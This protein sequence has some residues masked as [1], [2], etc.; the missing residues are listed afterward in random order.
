MVSTLAG[1]WLRTT[2]GLGRVALAWLIAGVGAAGPAL[3]HDG[4]GRGGSMLSLGD[5]VVFG[6]ITSD[7]PAY[8][9][10]DNFLGYPEIAGDSLR[11]DSVNAACPGETSAGFLS[12]T[13]PDYKCQ[14]FRTHFPLHES[15]GGTQLD[16][17]LA[18]LGAN[19][20]KTR[21]VTLSIGANDVFLLQAEC[22]G[23]A[24]CI[25]AGLPT[26]LAQLYA[27]VNTILSNLK[28]T[29]FK[30]VLMVVNYYS[31]DYSDPAQ[32]GLTLALNHALANAAAA[33]GAVVAD[34]FGAFQKVAAAAGGKTCLAGLLNGDPQNQQACDVH[35]SLS[36]QRLL[37]KAV[38]AAY[39][40][41]KR[42]DD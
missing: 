19:K 20:R 12:L 27:N 10:P 32:T 29:G 8:V 13:G 1:V 15:Y 14:P 26:L 34:A 22:G 2:R 28:A 41:G 35:P 11:L 37:A 30:G 38:E 36:G 40:G 21:L 23:G 17:A 5:S 33:N 6:Y 3:A 9:N 7:G 31:T 42:W 18:Y 25:Q 4:G 24:N 16:Y 39:R